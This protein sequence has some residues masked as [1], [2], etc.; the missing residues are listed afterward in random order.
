MKKLQVLTSLGALL[1]SLSA[2]AVGDIGVGLMLG[3][4]TGVTA[5]KILANGQAVDAGAGFSIGG[6]NT[7]QI[8]ADYLFNKQDALYWNDKDPLDLYFGLGGRMRFADEI[9]FGLRLPF[10]MAYFLNERS[11]ELFT[12]LAPIVNFIPS[13]NLQAQFVVGGRIY[14]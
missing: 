13:S 12:E 14:F 1:L 6:N 5:K 8:H 3:Y 10:G 9:E 2:F 7:F 4:P 11:L